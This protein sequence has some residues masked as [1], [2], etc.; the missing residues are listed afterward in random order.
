M[1]NHSQTE[2]RAT[3][4]QHYQRTLLMGMAGLKESMRADFPEL[5][6]ERY[7]EAAKLITRAMAQ[8]M[9]RQRLEQLKQMGKLK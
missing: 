6:D 2:L 9:A 4:E 3:L 1:I 5:D 8:E 7:P